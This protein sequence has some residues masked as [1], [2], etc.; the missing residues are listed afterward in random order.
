M[1]NNFLIDMLKNISSSMTL[2]EYSKGYPGTLQIAQAYL[3]K[4]EGFSYSYENIYTL[5]MYYNNSSIG[6]IKGQTPSTNNKKSINISNNKYQTE[7]VLKENNIRTTNSQLFNEELFAQAYSLVS[8]SDKNFVIKP[9]SLSGGR[10]ITLNVNKGNFESAWTLAVNA[11]KEAK[12]NIDILVQ[13]QLEGV[14]SRFIVIEGKFESAMLRVPANV[15]GDGVHSIDE[16]IDIK[17]SHRNKNPH[18]KRLPIKKD[19]QTL[20][21]LKEQNM[22]LKSIPL[23]DEII[24]LRLSSNVSQGGDNYEISHLVSD[25]MKKLSESAVSAIPGLN[26]AGV[27][28]LYKS[29]V[30]QFP[31]VLEVNPAA[32]WLRPQDFTTFAIFLTTK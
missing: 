24:F 22:N 3:E 29:F 32:N 13:E 19:H 25:Y 17:N 26:T 8:I 6:S 5:N 14:E 21:I 18:L 11:C 16:L 30:D 31:I 7:L 2:N 10:G 20:S 12:K 27:D 23:L 28:I 1:N 15:T 9:N 4:T